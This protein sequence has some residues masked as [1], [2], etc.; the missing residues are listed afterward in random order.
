MDSAAND[1]VESKSCDYTI[2]VTSIAQ[3]L[4]SANC[5]SVRAPGELVFRYCTV[6]V[7]V[8]TCVASLLL[9]CTK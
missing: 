2:H 1:D 4:K 8:G 3:L 6:E 7:L 9:N 5:N